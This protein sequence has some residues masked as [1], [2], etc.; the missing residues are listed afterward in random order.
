MPSGG[1]GGSSMLV[2]TSSAARSAST[3]SPTSS[4]RGRSTRRG[5]ESA[6]RILLVKFRLGLFDDPYVD[7]EQAALVVG[8]AEHRSAGMSAQSRSVVVLENRDVGE[9]VALPMRRGLRLYLEGVD[10]EVADRFGE[11]VATPDVADVA[12]VRLSAPFEPR[13]DLFLEAFFH[14]GSLEFRPGVVSRLARLAQTVPVLVDVGLDRAAVLTP[15]RDL[16]AALTVTF[17]VSDEA[18]LRA[19]TGDTPPEGRLP[20]MLPSSMDIVRAAPADAGIAANDALYPLGS[21]LDIVPSSGRT[22]NHVD[23]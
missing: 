6:L 20:I 1:C 4:R 17:G 9:S 2:P 15:I 14:Q 11:V 8:S 23:D 22:K 18:L 13:D 5:F 16:A 19:L 7:E 3:C 10:A 21:G 12:L